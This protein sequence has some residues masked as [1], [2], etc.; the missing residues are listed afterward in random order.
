MLV[1]KIGI[2]WKSRVVFKRLMFEISIPHPNGYIKWEVA[3]KS[4]EV[5]RKSGMEI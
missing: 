3:Y 1:R 5:K 4:L 2:G